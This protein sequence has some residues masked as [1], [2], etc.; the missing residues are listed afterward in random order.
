MS[1]PNCGPRPDAGAAVTELNLPRRESTNVVLVGNPNVGKSSLF[2]ALTGMRQT[3]VN[4]PGTTVEVFTGVN[5]ELGVRFIDTPGTYSLV[6][7]SPDEAVV[8]D[9]LAGVP[10]S[11]TDIG[12]VD[13]GIDLAVVVLDAT[14]LSRSLYLLAQVGQVGLPVVVALTMQDV[15]AKRKDA[16]D[17]DNLSCLLGVPVVAVNPRSGDGIDNAKRM[18]AGVLKNPTYLS[19]LPWDEGAP[20]FNKAAAVAAKAKRSAVLAEAEADA[21]TDTETAQDSAKGEPG[22]LLNESLKLNV[23][24]PCGGTNCQPGKPSGRPFPEQLPEPME[25]TERAALLFDWIESV[26]NGLHEERIEVPPVSRSDRVDRVLLHP[27]W[28]TLLFMV[29]MYVVFWL[30]NTFA[31]VFQDPFEGIFDAVGGWDFTV[32][33][34]LLKVP[35]TG[36]GVPG[37]DVV[38]FHAPSLADGVLTWLTWAGWD[39]G[40]LQGILIDGLLTGVGVVVSF[41]PLMLVMFAAIA[42]MEDSGYMARVAFLGDRLMRAIGLDGRVIMPFIVGFGCNLPTLAALRT[43]PDSRQRMMA[44]VLTPYI[45][46]SARMIVY[47][48]IAQVFFGT[49][50]TEVVWLMYLLSVVMVVLGGLVLRPVFL[51]GRVGAPLMLVLPAYQ[52]PRGLVLVRSAL[53]R[54][55]AFLKGAGKVIVVMTVVIW[56]L[57]VTPVSGEG[58]FGDSLPANESAYGVAASA[59]APVFAPAGFGDWHLTG[60]LITGFV[61][62]ETMLGA[63]AATYTDTAVSEEDI[64]AAQDAGEATP[65]MRDL[66]RSTFETSAGSAAAAPIAAIAFLIFVLT[67][68]PCLATVAEQWR[69]LGAR[70]TLAAVFGQLVVAWL[71]AVAVFQIGR[72]FV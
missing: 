25:E 59:I 20:G 18:I 5:R 61:A 54:T 6:P 28:G 34:D 23:I 29:A 30:A 26:T 68:T 3:V 21:A 53:S 19:G 2:N 46:C 71:L 37:E 70:R 16:I 22:N 66:T 8:V 56:A 14:A 49:H 39:G 11:I 35:F 65:T 57:M 9:T 40:V 51:R 17:V 32:P 24:S 64:A 33:A 36:I 48:F 38:L 31:A 41:A 7:T 50:A 43:V 1:C 52:A 12:R 27:L 69:Q 15:A 72:L 58:R 4:A 10:G 60:S 45:T 44:V 47:M 13:G 42:V 62:K 67:Y 55:W 63:L